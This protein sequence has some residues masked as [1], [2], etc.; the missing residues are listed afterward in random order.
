MIWGTG[1]AFVDE[2]VWVVLYTESVNGWNG[3]NLI[4]GYG[5]KF[6]I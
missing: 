2:A 3:G 5:A 4:F 1:V 6:I